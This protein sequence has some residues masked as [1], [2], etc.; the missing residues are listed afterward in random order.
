MTHLCRQS[1]DKAVMVERSEAWWNIP[2]AKLHGP[3]GTE[4]LVAVPHQ[5]PQVLRGRYGCWVSTYFTRL[6]FKHKFKNKIILYMI[7]GTHRP[8][9]LAW[10]WG[11][12]KSSKRCVG[13]K[14]WSKFWCLT[15]TWH[16]WAGT[17][18][19]SYSLWG[20]GERFKGRWQEGMIY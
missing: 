10:W 5:I 6:K 4:S 14:S 1:Y 20:Y 2:A 19:S 7:E 9:H 17:H 18:R 11:Q 15:H 3:E 16:C 12:R 8:M 13:Y